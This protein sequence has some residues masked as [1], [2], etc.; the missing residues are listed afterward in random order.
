VALQLDQVV[1]G[2][3]AA[4]LTGV[5]QT[6]EQ[7]ARLRP[8]QRPIEQGILPLQNGPLQC[9]NHFSDTFVRPVTLNACYARNDRS[10]E[11][12]PDG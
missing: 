4:Q 1:E 2:V 10:R 3:G 9:P 6:H 12:L 7:V 11:P 5:N 8:V